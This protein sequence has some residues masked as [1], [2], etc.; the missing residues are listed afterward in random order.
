MVAR[1]DRSSS[2]HSR[3][4]STPIRSRSNSEMHGRGPV[5]PQERYT[6]SSISLY[7]APDAHPRITFN[8]ENPD[9][10]GIPIT[11][12]LDRTGGFTRLRDR[13]Q[14]FDMEKKTFTLRVQVSSSIKFIYFM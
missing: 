8:L 10:I 1:H 2:I 11:D 5:I 9:Q 12:V 13:M 4:P 14:A 3:S 7:N 6:T